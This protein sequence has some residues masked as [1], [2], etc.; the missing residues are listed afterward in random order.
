MSGVPVGLIS[1]GSDRNETIIRDGSVVAINTTSSNTA[2]TIA[3]AGTLPYPAPN[4]IGVTVP[5]DGSTR[6]T[7][8]SLLSS[9]GMLLAR[10]LWADFGLLPGRMLDIL[11]V[12]G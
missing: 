8:I 11:P 9:A 12:K 2:T 6:A 7:K 3:P 10:Y 1:T 5:T 4:C